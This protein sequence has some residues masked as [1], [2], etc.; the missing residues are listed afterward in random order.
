MNI[1]KIGVVGAFAAGAAFAMAPL[2]AAD[3][4]DA[5]D[6]SNILLGQVQS[7][8]WLFGSQATA[9]GVE[10]DLINAGDPTL[11]DPLSFSTISADDLT[12]NP[13]FAAMLFGPNWEAEMSS[14]PGSYS[15]FNGALTQFY[16]A[17]NVLTYAL[18]T[19]GGEIDVADAGDYL[20]GSDTAIAESLEGDGFFAD[21]GNFFNAG[22]ADLFGYFGLGMLDM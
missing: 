18:M 13:A 6:F 11:E 10:G 21:F 14:D 20:F 17:S 22:M 5:P 3:P 2:A 7:M 16:D 9:S 1:R 4:G 19:G 8:N 12:D 15:L